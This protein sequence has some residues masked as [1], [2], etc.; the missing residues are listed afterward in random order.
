MVKAKIRGIYATALTKLLLDNG[1]EIVQPSIEVQKRFNLKF[2][3][4]P[5]DLNIYDRW[6][7]QGVHVCGESKAV[8]ALCKV[9]KENLLDVIIRRIE[10]PNVQ[11]SLQNRFLDVEFPGLSK[12]K[13]DDIRRCVVPTVKGHHYYKTCGIDISSAVDMAEKLI[14]KG[15]PIDKVEELLRL[16]IKHEYPSEGREID[17]EHVKL[18]GNILHLGKALVK[19]YDEDKGILKLHRSIKGE[20]VYDGLKVPKRIGDYALTEVKLGEWYL[21]TRYF[22]SENHYKG[23]Y[24][25]INTPVELYPRCIRYV[26]LEVDV[27][28]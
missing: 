27:C 3:E 21:K 24:V 11:S 23:M 17:I 14:A 20:G 8:E 26:D 10:Q 4:S 1:F 25:N 5:Y 7:K 9:L 12:A 19:V 16:T 2:D 15:S 6:D 28:I 13:L 22:S 18:D